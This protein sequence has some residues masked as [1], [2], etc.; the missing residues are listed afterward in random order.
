MMNRPG[1][2]RRATGSARRRLL[3]PP[4][5]EQT[6]ALRYHRRLPGQ[7]RPTAAATTPFAA[8]NQATVMGSSAAAHV[9]AMPAHIPSAS[10]NVSNL[11]A[12]TTAVE[13]AEV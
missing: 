5:P 10:V 8:A 9:A 6:V 11:P 1:A 3:R 12:A 13:G 4:L 7:P 2:A